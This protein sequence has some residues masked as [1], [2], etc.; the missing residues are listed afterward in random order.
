MTKE[1][2]AKATADFAAKG[3]KVAKVEE[4]KR[5]VDPL[6]KNCQCGCRGDWTDHTMR[7]GERGN[8]GGY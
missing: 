1:E 4:G 7:Q 3:G 2:L 8:Y 5:T 6:I